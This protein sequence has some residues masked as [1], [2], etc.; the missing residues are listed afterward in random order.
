MALALSSSKLLGTVN[1]RVHQDTHTTNVSILTWPHTDPVVNGECMNAV[2]YLNNPALAFH[3]C[4]FWVL[5]KALGMPLRHPMS[6]LNPS[7][8]LPTPLI[9]GGSS[10]YSGTRYSI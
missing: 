5:W 8:D 4:L 9:L 10:L 3:I 1:A 7:S 2:V 6:N